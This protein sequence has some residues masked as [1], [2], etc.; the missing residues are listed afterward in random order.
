M[1]RSL[2]G[3][4]KVSIVHHIL[5]LLPYGTISEESDQSKKNNK[6]QLAQ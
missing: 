3:D 2:F 1:S 5:Y 6:I 4:E